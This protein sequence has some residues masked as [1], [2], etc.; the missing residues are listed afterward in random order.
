MRT[1]VLIFATVLLSSTIVR[2]QDEQ[3]KALCQR[4]APKYREEFNKL[5]ESGSLEPDEATL[6][7]KADFSSEAFQHRLELDQAGMLHTVS[8]LQRRLY[9]AGYYSAVMEFI[10]PDTSLSPPRSKLPDTVSSYGVQKAYALGYLHGS[11]RAAPVAHDLLASIMRQ[12]LENDE[13]EAARKNNT[14]PK[15]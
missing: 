8:P 11:S 10:E 4:A 3:L 5:V 13:A 2:S 12:H 6:Q 14:A 7:V 1:P 9:L 15:E